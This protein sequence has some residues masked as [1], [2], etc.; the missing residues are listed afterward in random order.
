MSGTSKI[1][2]RDLMSG[3]AAL[4][5][6]A[7]AAP[8]RAASHTLSSAEEVG[9]WLITHD[10]LP[11]HRGMLLAGLTQ[12]DTVNGWQAIVRADFASGM[13]V[14]VDGWLISDT[15]ARLCALAALDVEPWVGA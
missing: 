4:S 12:P 1:S 13:M 15:E 3:L 11:A 14:S 9:K 10:V 8:G 7:L 5:F 6:G 2:R